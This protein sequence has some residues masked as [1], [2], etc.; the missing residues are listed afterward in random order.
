[1]YHHESVLTE[2]VIAYLQPQRGGTFLD[3]TLGGGGHSLALLRGG[4]HR[5]MG[6]DQDPAAIQAARARFVA[7]G[8][9]GEDP[10]LKLWH[11]NFA[12]FDLQQHGFRDEQGNGIPFDGVVADLG[13]SSPQL[14]HPERG[15]SFR[16]EGP[17][18]MRMDPSTDQE[19]AADW[20]NHH[21]VEELIDIFSR[22]GEE[23]FARRIAHRIEQSRPFST[24]TQLADV[25]W[26]AVPP[27]ARRGRIHPATRVFQALRIAVNRELEV[28]ETLL[29]QAPTWLKPTGRLA[30]ISFH[31]LEDRLVKWAFRRD[32]RWQVLTPKPLQPSE[33]ELRHNPRARSAKLRVA[34]RRNDLGVDRAQ[35]QKIGYSESKSAEVYL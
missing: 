15:F 6:L 7:E 28:L 9:P 12:E 14:D 31:S 2:E 1:M 18:D 27:A 4:A 29:A 16:H 22:Y 24:T 8:I 10:R 13:V 23:R 25:I 21:D 35:S 3:V 17:L 32:P 34:A 30:V 19:T 11:L 33:P 26:Q 20:V 5:V